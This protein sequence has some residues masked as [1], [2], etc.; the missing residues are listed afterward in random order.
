MY[1][2][3]VINNIPSRDLAFIEERKHSHFDEIGFHEKRFLSLKEAKNYADRNFESGGEYFSLSQL[4]DPDNFVH[5]IADKIAYL[6]A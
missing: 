6:M 3:C 4:A 5:M 2:S 1:D